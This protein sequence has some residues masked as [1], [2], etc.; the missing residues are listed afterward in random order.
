VKFK[1]REIRKKDIKSG[2]TLEKRAKKF[3]PNR[4]KRIEITSKK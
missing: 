4:C 2:R 1:L 3:T